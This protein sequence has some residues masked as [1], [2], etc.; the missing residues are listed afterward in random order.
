MSESVDPYIDPATG[1]LR[2]R[3]GATTQAA[4]D[5]AEGDLS[6]L[7]LVELA[8]R[9]RLRP[10]GDLA[11]VCGI[12]RHLFGDLYEWAGKIR[13]VDI[14]KPGAE[15]F[16]PVSR[17]S[18]G[19]GFVFN[20]LREDNYLRT[21]SRDKLVDRLACHY[22][23]LNYVHP[24]REGNGRTQRVFWS[25]VASNAGWQLDWRLASRE[26]NNEASRVAAELSDLRPLREMFDA[27]TTAAIPR[28]RAAGQAA[29]DAARLAFGNPGAEATRRQPGTPRASPHR[30]PPGPI[31]ERARGIGD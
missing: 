10:T 19:A 25:W 18:T 12:H 2:N 16:L 30:A 11:E 20:E 6:L 27:I 1:I 29:L 3:I 22:D 13:T 21:M 14:R 7:R 17:I 26:A 9:Y 15:P 8:D 4:L 31:S 28:G 5:R 24:F 23:A